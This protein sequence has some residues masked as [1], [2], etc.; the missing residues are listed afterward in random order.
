MLLLV[1]INLVKIYGGIVG[2]A[3][4]TPGFGAPANVLLALVTIGLTIVFARVLRGYFGQLSVLFGLLAGTI[5]AASRA[6]WVFRPSC[7]GP[8]RDREVDRRP[9]GRPA[10]GLCV[11]TIL[12]ARGLALLI[13]LSTLAAV[14]ASLLAPDFRAGRAAARAC[15]PAR[16]A[17]SAPGQR[18]RGGF[19]RPYSSSRSSR[20][21]SSSCGRKPCDALS[22]SGRA[23]PR[24]KLPRGTSR[25]RRSSSWRV[26]HPCRGP[27]HRPAR[28]GAAGTGRFLLNH[29]SMSSSFCRRSRLGVQYAG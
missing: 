18:M 9:H 27:S 3:A 2:G 5:I 7:P 16:V 15:L 11:L 25:R 8:G 29:G 13:G 6:L 19:A 1:G 10:D 28:G 14:A 21:R 17:T 24:A 12:S 26:A 23:P 4:G 20:P 22:A